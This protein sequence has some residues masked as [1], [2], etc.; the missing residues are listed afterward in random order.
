MR[1]GQGGGLGQDLFTEDFVG[2]PVA[3]TLPGRGVEAL[4]NRRQRAICQRRRIRVSWQES[5]R[6]AVGVF[7]RPLLPWGLR[8]TEPDRDAK[9]CLQVGPGGELEAAV[10]GNGPARMEREGRDPR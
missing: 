4:T 2:C 6:A 1:L 3:Q 9:T 10:E 7:I 8:V 5:P